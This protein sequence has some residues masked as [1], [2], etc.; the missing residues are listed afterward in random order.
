MNIIKEYKILLKNKLIFIKDEF[1]MST[2]FKD[3]S[4]LNI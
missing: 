1:E 4:F 2:S 3:K